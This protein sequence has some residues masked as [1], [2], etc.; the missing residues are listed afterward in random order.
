MN[1]GAVSG[2]NTL[3]LQVRAAQMM[4]GIDPSRAR[5][6]F[7]WIELNLGPASCESLLVPSVDEYYTALSLLARTA[8]ADRADGLRFL[9]LYLWRAHLP[10]EMPSVARAVLRFQPKRDEAAYL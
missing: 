7:E 6:I 4:A 9:E 8:F 1:A 2:S 5:E 10:S 3:S